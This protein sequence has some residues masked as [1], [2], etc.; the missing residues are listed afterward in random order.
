MPDTAALRFGQRLRELR[1][2]QGL[3]QDDLW[4]T[5]GIHTTAISRLERGERE[6]RL[7]TILRLADGLAAEPGELLVGAESSSDAQRAAGG[8]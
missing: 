7:S 6:P 8:G 1:Y 3:S 2:E 5:S 4:Q